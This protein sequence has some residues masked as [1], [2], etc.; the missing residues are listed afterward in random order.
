MVEKNLEG[1][2][3]RKVGRGKNDENTSYV[4]KN[5]GAIY[6][7]NILKRRPLQKNTAN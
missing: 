5:L 1:V 3:S 2:V 7:N 4:C 6:E